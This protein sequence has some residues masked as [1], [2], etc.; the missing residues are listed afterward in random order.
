MHKTRPEDDSCNKTLWLEVDAQTL[1]AT[2]SSNGIGCSFRIT[3]CRDENEELVPTA[4]LGDCLSKI[5]ESCFISILTISKDEVRVVL[6]M[7]IDGAWGLF[8]VYGRTLDFD[9][10]NVDTD[11][12]EKS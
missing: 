8:E 7:P 10:Y 5:I 4:K 12:W 11:R 2:V 6:D 9:D 3:C 1:L